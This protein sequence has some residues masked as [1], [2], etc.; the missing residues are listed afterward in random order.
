MPSEAEQW[1]MDTCRTIKDELRLQT[2]AIVRAVLF[3]MVRSPD[4]T[5]GNTVRSI[6][7]IIMRDVYGPNEDPRQ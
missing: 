4:N 3:T 1:K 7:D 5:T 6:E 2:R